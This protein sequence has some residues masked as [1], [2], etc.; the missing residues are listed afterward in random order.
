MMS[1][2]LG[3]F[4]LVDITMLRPVLAWR[5]F[6]NLWTMYFFTFPLFFS[7]PWPTADNWIRGY[8][9]RGYG[10]QLILQSVN[11]QFFWKEVT[12]IHVLNLGTSRTLHGTVL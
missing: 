12:E 8:W 7:G 2:L 10:G 11:F 9:I 1:Q 5:A 6:L 3:A 4:G